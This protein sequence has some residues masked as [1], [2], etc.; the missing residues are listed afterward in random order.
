MLDIYDIDD[1]DTY[2]LYVGAQV[3][4]PICD[5]IRNIQVVMRNRELDNNVKGGI[6]AT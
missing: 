3:R 4:V 1:V 5:E 2:D 6:N